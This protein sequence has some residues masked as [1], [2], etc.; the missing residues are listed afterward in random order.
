MTERPTLNEFV[1]SEKNSKESDGNSVQEVEESVQEMFGIGQIPREWDIQP[2]ANLAEVIAGNSPPSSTYNEDENGLPFFQGNSEFGHF[3]PEAD[4]WCSEPRKIAE[5]DDILISIRA[6]VG[7][8][9]IA[10]QRCCIGRGLTALRQKNTSGLYLYYHL[11][12]RKSWLSRLATGSTFKSITKGD[13]QNL[14]IPRPPLEEQRKIATVLHTV[15]QAIQKTE[16]IIEQLYTVRDS[17]MREIFNFGIG[18]KGNLRSPEDSAHKFKKTPLGRIPE[19][20]ECVRLGKIIDRSG[21]FIQTGPFGSQLHKKEYVEE[22]I[23][24]VMPQNIEESKIL[25]DEIAKITLEKANDLA[26][27]RMEPNDVIIARRGDLERAASISKR[28]EGWLCGTGC[29]L[30]RPPESEIYRE[31]L[32]MAYQHPRSQHQINSRAVGSTMSNLNQSILESLQIALPPVEEQERITEIISNVDTRIGHENTY[33]SRLQRLKQGL[34]QDLLS[35]EVRTTNTNIEVPE[36][37]AK[38]G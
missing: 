17:L 31:W 14:D 24:V 18:Y 28:E 35:G 6:P 4:T 9:N 5:T 1:D 37:V 33:S 2:L 21:G 27:H 26:R 34:M 25:K 16:E 20:W 11:A 29:L 13:L 32:R 38:Y 19:S 7:D 30:I 12:E 10:D 8:L 3:H 23:P 15:D 36:E 22:G